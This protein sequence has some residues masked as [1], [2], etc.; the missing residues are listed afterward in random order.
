MQR[1]KSMRLFILALLL[2]AGFLSEVQA[3]DRPPNFVVIM[4]DDLG[5]GD[6][7]VYGSTL[8]RTPN[9]DR[10]SHEGA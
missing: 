4:A 2:L 10:M 5:Y 8:I 6:L 3:Q 9:I 7:F 1:G